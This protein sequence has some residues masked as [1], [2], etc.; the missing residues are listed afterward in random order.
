MGIIKKYETDMLY[1]Q[2]EGYNFS[3]KV[4]HLFSTR[5]GW[6]QDSLFHN[7]SE[8]FNIPEENIYRV[9]QVHGKDVLIINY[10]NN[11]ELDMEEK[12]GLITQK[13]GIAL[14]TYHADCVPIYFYDSIKEIIGVA[15][16]G[17]K[18]TLNNI[19][20]AMI[21]AMVKNYDSN[22]DNIFVA[23]GPSIG[24]CCYE[25]GQDVETLFM[26]KYSN[27]EG[28]IIKR[29]D[30]TYLDL[31][32]ANKANLLRSGIN[33]N[34]IF[35]SETCTACNIDTLHSYRKEKGTRNRMIAAIMLNE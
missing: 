10:Q 19:C 25:I 29:E 34:N 23:I 20:E 14:C 12:D 3:N 24:S 13:K 26:D 33:Y 18:G 1:Y 5:I 15:H 11:K 6:D 35:C 4:N 31:W 27:N 22:I 32:E 28:I 17:W 16:A 21:N 7:L 8:V 9:R 2:I 30:K